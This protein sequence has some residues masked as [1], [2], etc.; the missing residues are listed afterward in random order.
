M[1]TAFA[2]AGLTDRELTIIL[3]ALLVME[4]VD[5]KDANSN[6]KKARRAS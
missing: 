2:N 4:K 6:F 5:L 1:V 3:G